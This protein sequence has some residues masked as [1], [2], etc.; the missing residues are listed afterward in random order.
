LD[1]SR[2]TGGGCYGDSALQLFIPRDYRMP[3]DEVRAT[4]EYL[5]FIELELRSARAQ[6]EEDWVIALLEDLARQMRAALEE[7]RGRTGPLPFCSI[8]FERTPLQTEDGRLLAYTKPLILLVDEFTTSWGDVFASVI[9]DSGRGPLVGVRTNGA[10]GSIDSNI[11]G[12][13]SEG[14]ASFSITNGVRPRTVSAA[15]YPVSA[16]L[17]NIGVHPDMPLDF[18]TRENLVTR[19]EPFVA[20]F[21]AAV[22]DE[23]AKNAQQPRLPLPPR[24]EAAASMIGLN[25]D[26]PFSRE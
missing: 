5:Y 23:I 22:L 12:Y 1:I 4:L 19:G 11:V 2:N 20:A 26:I 3:G 25:A 24:A 7:N 13:F 6:E 9:Q 10:G 15:G 18:M 21:T 17:E 16:Y 8:G 14:F